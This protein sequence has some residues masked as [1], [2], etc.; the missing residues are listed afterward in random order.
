MPKP[1]Y[2]MP[3]FIIKMKIDQFDFKLS[4]EITVRAHCREDAE[5]AA[6]MVLH[7][8][9]GVNFKYEWFIKE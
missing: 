4:A 7:S 6:E 3:E 2:D 8:K 9:F 1:V 5:L